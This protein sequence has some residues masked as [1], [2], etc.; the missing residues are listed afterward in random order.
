[1]DIVDDTEQVLGGQPVK[2]AEGTASGRLSLTGWDDCAMSL[3]GEY[4]WINPT[5]FSRL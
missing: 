3:E 2:D 1:M 4:L 5:A